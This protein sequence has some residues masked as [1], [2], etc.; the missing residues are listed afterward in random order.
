MA[1]AS[2]RPAEVEFQTRQGLGW[3]QGMP[4]DSVESDESLWPMNCQYRQARGRAFIS[5]DFAVFL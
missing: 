4:L 1:Q 2:G 5:R 3:E